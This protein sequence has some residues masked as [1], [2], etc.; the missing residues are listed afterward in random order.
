MKVLYRERKL[1][2][3]PDGYV[4]MCD[5]LWVGWREAPGWSTEA[6]G[7][8]PEAGSDFY[9]ISISDQLLGICVSCH[10]AWEVLAVCLVLWDD[11]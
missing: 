10:G 7:A 1:I 4:A 11:V 6:T 3:Y 8:S 9:N 2:I 5:V